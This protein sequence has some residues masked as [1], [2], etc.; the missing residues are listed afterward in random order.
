MEVDLRV[1]AAGS[2][3]EEKQVGFG[4][5][6]E[7]VG[8]PLRPEK[9]TKRV[10]TVCQELLVKVAGVQVCDLCNIQRQKTAFVWKNDT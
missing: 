1:E 3:F 5:R 9:N 10:K 2:Q 7:L 6:P 8:F 4:Q